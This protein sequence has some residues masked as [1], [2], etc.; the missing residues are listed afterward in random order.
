MKIKLHSEATRELSA[1][2]DWYE[3][4]RPGL[5]EVF[6]REVSRSIEAIAKNPRIW[7]IWPGWNSRLRIP[8]FVLFRFPF[9]IAYIIRRQDILILAIA[10]GRRRPGYWRERT[11]Q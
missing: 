7:P 1:S 4:Q 8:R 9:S 6:L 3:E 11:S 2:A 5:G 10:H